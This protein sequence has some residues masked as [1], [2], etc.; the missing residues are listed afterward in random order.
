VRWVRFLLECQ[1]DIV[2]IDLVLCL[3]CYEGTY[4]I[5]EQ[6]A[7]GLRDPFAGLDVG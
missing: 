5:E 4:G 7:A 1:A 3:S 2:W 6:E